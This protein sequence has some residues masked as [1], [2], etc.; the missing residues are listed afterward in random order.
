[1]FN[2]NSFIRQPLVVTGVVILLLALVFTLIVAVPEYPFNTNVCETVACM[3]NSISHFKHPLWIISGLIS[4]LVITNLLFKTT[5]SEKT[6]QYSIAQNTFSNY[7]EHRKQ[8]IDYITEHHDLAK[9]IC[10]SK[11]THR[12]YYP[13]AGEGK[14]EFNQAIICAIKTNAQILRYSLCRKNFSPSQTTDIAN[15]ILAI[16]N[17]LDIRELAMQLEA[18]YKLEPRD[19]DYIRAES[20]G[21]NSLASVFISLPDY[22]YFENGLQKAKYVND[23]IREI[24]LFFPQGISSELIESPLG[25]D[26]KKLEHERAIWFSEEYA[27]E[28][29]IANQRKLTSYKKSSS[30]S[31]TSIR[32]IKP[33]Y[34]RSTKR[35]KRS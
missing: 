11:R 26:F 2:N 7:F 23:Y 33:L 4:F 32:S 5:I 10:D 31:P 16:C 14:L 8:F 1:M 17:A 34:K 9:L 18:L 22:A 19:L 12:R 25:I 20:N 3:E 15:A 35:H 28:F 27:E 13:K 29:E 6:L 21:N 30:K 24:F